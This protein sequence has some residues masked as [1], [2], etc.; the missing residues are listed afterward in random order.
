MDG[1][2]IAPQTRRALAGFR[3]TLNRCG[4][5][6]SIC[7]PGC[8]ESHDRDKTPGRDHWAPRQVPRRAAPPGVISA[9]AR[10]R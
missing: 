3:R 9:G 6:P 10:T 8:A 7:P 2:A 4:T 1:Y 5:M